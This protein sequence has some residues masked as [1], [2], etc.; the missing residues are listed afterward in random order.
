MRHPPA[1]RSE[2]P[3]RTSAVT[4]L[5]IWADPAGGPRGGGAVFRVSNQ[6]SRITVG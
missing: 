3:R 4:E 6:Q 5:D 1:H 2:A